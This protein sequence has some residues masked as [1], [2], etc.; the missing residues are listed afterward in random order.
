VIASTDCFICRKHQGEF[1]VKGGCIYEDDLVYVGH[2]GSDEPLIYVGYLIVDLKRHA[3]GYGDMSD[4]EARAIGFTL[5]RLGRVLKDSEEAEHVYSFV[6]G[7]AFPHF[8]V[9]LIPRYKGTPK[10]YWH[11][12]NIR[13]YQKAYGTVDQIEKLCS[14]L[15][16]ALLHDQESHT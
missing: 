8:H 3:A 9:H 1:E 12:T 14:R 6:Q 7:D 4:D 2:I 13:S 10:E 5:N 16:D 15:R 11:P